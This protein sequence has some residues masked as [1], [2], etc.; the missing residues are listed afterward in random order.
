VQY[1]VIY[2]DITIGIIIYAFL[3]SLIGWD[4]YRLKKNFLLGTLNT[5]GQVRC[6]VR[7][8]KQTHGRVKLQR[9][10]EDIERQPEPYKKMASA[11]SIHLWGIFKP[12]F[13]RREWRKGKEALNE[14]DTPYHDLCERGL[15][16]TGDILA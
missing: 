7:M 16:Y 9:A 10:F 1:D 5:V 3:G 14:W 4:M 12:E 11:L 6:L 13:A 8:G 2:E 15:L